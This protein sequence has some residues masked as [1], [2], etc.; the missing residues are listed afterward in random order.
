M[1]QLAS[2]ESAIAAIEE[3]LIEKESITKTQIGELITD[4]L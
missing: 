1:G 2:Y 3:V 4:V